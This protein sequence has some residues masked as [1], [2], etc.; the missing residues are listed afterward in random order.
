MHVSVFR[1]CICMHTYIHIH[2][3]IQVFY[4]W[5]SRFWV[6]A[7]SRRT[8]HQGT[9]CNWDFWAGIVPLSLMHMIVCVFVSVCDCVCVCKCVCVCAKTSMRVSR[10]TYHQ[11][12]L[13]YWDVWASILH[14]FKPAHIFIGSTQPSHLKINKNKWQVLRAWY[15]ETASVRAVRTYIHTYIHFYQ[16]TCIWLA[17]KTKQTNGRFSVHGT[18]TMQHQAQY[19]HTFISYIHFYWMVGNTA[20]KAN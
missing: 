14:I 1:M 20:Y 13:T 2:T 11:G 12:T 5:I 6:F 7:P 9:L 8:Y 19:A 16:I 10:R 4:P 17:S 3:H 18:P 15:A